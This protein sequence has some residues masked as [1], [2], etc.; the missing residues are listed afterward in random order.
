VGVLSQIRVPRLRRLLKAS[1]RYRATENLDAG[2][3]HTSKAAPRRRSAGRDGAERGGDHAGS[4][5]AKLIWTIPTK[6]AH[7]P[8]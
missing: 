3:Y 5:V 4:E 2:V 1:T 6:Q 8:R 7:S